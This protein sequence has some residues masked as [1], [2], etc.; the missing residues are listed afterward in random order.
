MA[1]KSPS[2]VAWS[3]N[4]RVTGSNSAYPPGMVNIVGTVAS[5]LK[6]FC[7]IS[8]NSKRRTL[9]LLKFLR[10]SISGFLNKG[11]GASA[12]PVLGRTSPSLH[13]DFRGSRSRQTLEF[14]WQ[15]SEF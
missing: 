11:F 2:L 9:L 4:I 1:F 6:S 3:T 5:L 14:D 15:W 13:L 7:L 12:D 8:T 10:D